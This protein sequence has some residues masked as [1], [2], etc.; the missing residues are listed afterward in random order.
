MGMALDEPK[1][2]DLVLEREGYRLVFDPEM[3]GV[4][5]S[6]GGLKIDYVDQPDQKGFRVV[7]ADAAEGCG[8]GGCSC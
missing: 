4:I 6:K 7:L 5:R 3:T 2:E 8:T 1:Q